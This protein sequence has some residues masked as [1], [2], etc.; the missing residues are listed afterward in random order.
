MLGI[1]FRH[2]PIL[3]YLDTET[4]YIHGGLNDPGLNP[5]TRH[6]CLVRKIEI[7]LVHIIAMLLKT[8]L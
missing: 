8:Q 2:Q 7:N 3:K 1:I 6:L 4:S 5:G